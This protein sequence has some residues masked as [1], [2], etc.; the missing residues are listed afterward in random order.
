MIG[1]MPLYKR[2][3][4]TK[5]KDKGEEKDSLDQ[6]RLSAEPSMK[7]FE[8]IKSFSMPLP[9]ESNPSNPSDNSMTGFGS[10]RMSHTTSSV[11]TSKISFNSFGTS[12]DDY[13]TNSSVMDS[14]VFVPVENAS[15][16]DLKPPGEKEAPGG[17]NLPDDL[18]QALD[19]IYK[20]GGKPITIPP[21]NMVTPTPAI[22]ESVTTIPTGVPPP[23]LS[24]PPTNVPPPTSTA[25]GKLKFAHSIRKLSTAHHR[26]LLT[27]R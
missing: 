16:N 24:L 14:S 27:F 2:P 10:G 15:D 22:V 5:D 17:T 12:R 13:G 11:S 26:W 19:I 6:A 21:P 3:L 9:D 20:G 7:S 8:G 25:Y 4:L 23:P 18:Q 1:K